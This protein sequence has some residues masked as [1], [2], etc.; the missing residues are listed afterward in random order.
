MDPNDANLDPGFLQ[1]LAQGLRSYAS[2]PTGAP[3]P[4]PLPPPGPAAMQ[5]Q[6]APPQIQPPAPPQSQIDPKFV[7]QASS[8]SP[9]YE[10]PDPTMLQFIIQALRQRSLA[11]DSPRDT[12]FHHGRITSARG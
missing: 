1:L 10:P 6:A 12:S 11:P 8:S 7:Q 3:N 2:N 4:T 5:R 9:Q